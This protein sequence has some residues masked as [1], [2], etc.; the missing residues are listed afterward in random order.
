MVREL[1][2]TISSKKMSIAKKGKEPW[3]KGLKY[4]DS[5]E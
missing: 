4:V 3:N 2:C 5:S 1:M